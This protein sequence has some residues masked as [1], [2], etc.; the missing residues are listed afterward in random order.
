MDGEFAD[1]K[2]C[3]QHSGKYCA[4]NVR[5]SAIGQAILT[6]NA[7]LIEAAMVGPGSVDDMAAQVFRAP[8]STFR[9]SY[10]KDLPVSVSWLPGSTATNGSGT[11]AEDLNCSLGAG[12]SYGPPDLPTPVTLAECFGHCR[13]DPKC[14]AV[15]VNWFTIPSNW[16]AMKIGCGLRGGI[17]LAK[18]TIQ[19]PAYPSPH[20]VQ[21]S[22]FAVDATNRSQ[23]LIAVRAVENPP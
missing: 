12:A 14:D 5:S 8:G 16:T 1:D 10:L 9:A 20:S 6:A 18:C 23:L 15:R 2:I 13:E 4:P 7:S 22:T 17:D 19:A 21:Y 3:P 11:F